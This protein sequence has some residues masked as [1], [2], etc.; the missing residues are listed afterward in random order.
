MHV[1][2]NN[3]FKVSAASKCIAEPSTSFN[4]TGDTYFTVKNMFKTTAQAYREAQAEVKRL[5]EMLNANGIDPATGQK[6]ESA[7][8]SQPVDS[9]TT[10]PKS[11]RVITR[12]Q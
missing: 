1:I 2:S 8:S 9:V 5:T 6:L 10:T 3:Q 7:T 11:G 12:V 4:R